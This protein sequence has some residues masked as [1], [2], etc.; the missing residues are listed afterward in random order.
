MPRSWFDTRGLTQAQINERVLDST[1]LDGQ[2]AA[3]TVKG[4]AIAVSAQFVRLVLQIL[5]MAALARLLAP[6]QFGLIAMAAT[7]MALLTA[8]TEL[9]VSTV[10]VQRREI[11]Q[12][13]V[14]ALLIVSLGM[15]AI[16]IVLCLAAMPLATWFFKDERVGAIVLAM[17]AAAPINA[18]GGHQYALLSRNMR[19]V[20][21]QIASLSGLAAGMAAAIIAAWAFDAGYWALVIQI[22]VSAAVGATLTWIFCP[23]RPSAVRDWS[24][25]KQGLSF[26][27]N[28]TGAMLL[29]YVHRQ[30]DNIL[31]GWRWGS[32]E[33]GHYARAY[34]LL[35][36]PLNFIS[37]PLGTAMIPALSRIQD[38]PSKWRAG[39]LDALAVV[40]M[41]GAGLAALLYGAATPI[42]ELVLGSGWERAELIFA[43]LCIGLLATVPMDTTGWIY[44]SRGRTD[45]MLQWS[46]IGVPIYLA[47][48]VIGLPYGAIGVALC[49]SISRYLTFVPC[50]WFATRG[51]PIGLRDVFIT[52]ATPSLAAIAVALGL[53]F[54][55]THL[56]PLLDF[57]ALAFAGVLYA[58]AMI[59]AIWALPP[60]HRV[61]ERAAA[62]IVTLR[63]KLR[64]A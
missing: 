46:L 62:A 29:N 64:R 34:A 50:F 36:T 23:W 45:R 25:A 52:I 32:E 1:H 3:R 21:I 60:Y 5:S 33:L 6:E 19:W 8:L 55:T 16:T 27:V 2:L 18:L 4:G 48:F 57:V 31:I 30:F 11:D 47:A 14:S 56:G 15:A 38:D 28:L 49:Y 54:A 13:T 26:G 20:D 24:G 12:D 41:A 59:T 10:A 51:T 17:A 9:N 61:R 22:W 43:Y 39:Y 7:V 44:I 42:I 53:N 35:M 40:T 37:G 63:L 58:L